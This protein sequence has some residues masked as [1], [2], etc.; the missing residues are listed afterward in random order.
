MYV[1][2]YPNCTQ[3]T[4]VSAQPLS[5]LHQIVRVQ[6]ISNTDSFSAHS[7][8]NELHIYYGELAIISM[9]LLRLSASAITKLNEY[10]KLSVL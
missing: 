4:V 10:E 5:E 9:A 6:F 2:N 1:I 7:L 8:A 3:L